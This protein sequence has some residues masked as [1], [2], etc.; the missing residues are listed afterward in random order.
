MSSP[1]NEADYRVT[2]PLNLD[3]IERILAN[4]ADA[5]PEPDVEPASDPAPVPTSAPTPEPVYTSVVPT[6][7]HETTVPISVPDLKRKGGVSSPSMEQLSALIVDAPPVTIMEDSKPL[8]FNPQ[9]RG[10]DGGVMR[11]RGSNRKITLDVDAPPLESISFASGVDKTGEN[12]GLLKSWAVCSSNDASM[13]KSVRDEANSS[14]L[15]GMR[16]GC[17]EVIYKDS[18]RDPEGAPLDYTVFAGPHREENPAP[19]INLAIQSATIA[20]KT[21]CYGTHGDSLETQRTREVEDEE[22]PKLAS[23]LPYNGNIINRQQWSPIPLQA[24]ILFVPLVFF[25]VVFITQL[26]TISSASSKN[27]VKTSKLLTNLASYLVEEQAIASYI[28]AYTTRMDTSDLKEF[29]AS[30][31]SS[32]TL[33]NEAKANVDNVVA[34]IQEEIGEH[35]SV[36]QEPLSPLPVSDFLDSIQL[37]IVRARTLTTTHNWDIMMRYEELLNQVLV[38]RGVLILQDSIQAN[39]ELS[40]TR[41]IFSTLA[42]FVTK[43]LELFFEEL[44]LGLSMPCPST[45]FD[46]SFLLYAVGTLKM[47]ERTFL[48]PATPSILNVFGVSTQNVNILVSRLPTSIENVILDILNYTFDPLAGTLHDLSAGE[49]L[50]QMAIDLTPAME[51]LNAPLRPKMDKYRTGSDYFALVFLYLCFGIACIGLVWHAINVCLFRGSGAEHQQ[52]NQTNLD[53]RSATIRMHEAVLKMMQLNIKDVSQ[54][55]KMIA[56]DQLIGDEERFLYIGNRTVQRLEPYL[57]LPMVCPPPEVPQEALLYK[58]LFI[59]PTLLKRERLVGLRIDFSNVLSLGNAGMQTSVVGEATAASIGTSG[60]S[61][62]S[63]TFGR[64]R[65]DRNTTASLVQELKYFERVAEI[66]RF[67]CDVS[68]LLLDS[69]NGAYISQCGEDVFVWVNVCEN[70]KAPCVIA[71]LIAM[72]IIEYCER[73]NNDVPFIGLCRSDGVMGNVTSFSANPSNTEH[74]VSTGHVA[75]DTNMDSQLTSSSDSD[76]DLA[77]KDFAAATEG[78]RTKKRFQRWLRQLLGMKL[79]DEEALLIP[80]KSAAKKLHTVD[81]DVEYEVPLPER[82]ENPDLLTTNSLTTFIVYGDVLQESEVCLEVGRTH[83]QQLV[84]NESFYKQLLKTRGHANVILNRLPHKAVW[85][86]T[87]DP[88]ESLLP[89]NSQLD[90]SPRIGFPQ[91]RAKEAEG[92]STVNTVVAAVT[93]RFADECSIFSP[94]DIVATRRRCIVVSVDEVLTEKERKKREK[95]ARHKKEEEE[96][97]APLS[98]ADDNATVGEHTEDGEQTLDSGDSDVESTDSDEPVEGFTPYNRMVDVAAQTTTVDGTKAV[99]SKRQTELHAYYTLHIAYPER[100]NS[101]EA[102]ATSPIQ[103]RREEEQT[104]EDWKVCVDQ[105]VKFCYE[106]ESMSPISVPLSPGEKTVLLDLAKQTEGQFNVFFDDHPTSMLAK[107]SAPRML[108]NIKSIQT[109]CQEA[110]MLPVG[111]RSFSPFSVEAMQLARLHASGHSQ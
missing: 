15:R 95:K 76:E 77:W 67:A 22:P 6:K 2:D 79:H 80:T 91:F 81:Q 111:L 54:E 38:Y 17:I 5:E 93:S 105:Y 20:S 106:A 97:L 85:S 101:T 108:D 65:R 50:L 48:F 89:S 78:M 104:V 58:R 46:I 45:S 44:V 87:I 69:E 57:P 21:E 7:V 51:Q 13:N 59:R 98:G 25:V 64:R 110:A 31:L 94:L 55:I 60:A 75:F 92:E 26:N 61:F 100:V 53:M 3:D 74:N 68:N 40:Q 84:A 29:Y 71:Y 86:P 30:L 1:S 37:A 62:G 19:P 99:T 8:T 36:L 35:W 9:R 24:L 41:S 63:L 4:V 28:C 66:L 39:S 12:T 82:V 83:S 18:C 103:A 70:V 102:S 42:L 109:I 14:A 11:R 56:S 52:V 73:F 32:R 34:A 88:G 16:M 27:I 90:A 47:V 10:E 96:T 107:Y 49:E 23:E 43:S 33:Y 72:S